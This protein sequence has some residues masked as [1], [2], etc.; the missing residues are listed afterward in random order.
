[1]MNIIMAL[2][3]GVF[4]GISVAILIVTMV[5]EQSISFGDSKGDFETFSKFPVRMLKKDNS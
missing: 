1:M 5:L 3:L 2:L 4:T